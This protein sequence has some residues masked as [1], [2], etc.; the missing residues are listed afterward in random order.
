MQKRTGN[1]KV[2]FAEIARELDI[3][4]MTLYR[5]VNQS[6][7]VSSRTRSRV[8]EALNR[9]G[10][11]THKRIKKV[12]ILFDFIS[13]N[14]YLRNMGEQLIKRLPPGEYFCRTCNHRENMQEFLNTA[15]ECDV[16]VFC[17]IPDNKLLEE[18]RKLNPDLY[19][20]TLSTESCADVTVTPDNKLGG[21][22]VAQHLF[23]LGQGHIAV[24]LSENHPNR[25]TRY[26]SFRG[27]MA[28]LNPECRID[29]IHHKKNEA[30]T[31]VLE[32]YFAKAE[33]YPGVIFFPSGGYAQAFWERFVQKDPARFAN[34]G[35]MSYDRPCDI[36]QDTA[37]IQFFDR[38]EFIPQQILDWAEYYITNR[39]M[40]KKRSPVHT[41]VN[42]YLVREGSVKNRSSAMTSNRKDNKCQK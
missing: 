22:L 39:P 4:V 12:K 37:G 17:S 21:E 31:D 25:M 23:E 3:S 7:L 20:I 13:G 38:I 32:T 41:C 6:P 15:A 29:E 18:L 8:I 35:I 1:L 33:P 28:V 36:F 5:V 26:K 34:I 27:E 40:M 10:Y 2:N 19:T 11:F 24:F 9:H 30:F 14:S 42:S 16:A